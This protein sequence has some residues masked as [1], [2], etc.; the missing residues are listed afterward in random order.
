MPNS[1]HDGA[2][3]MP[4]LELISMLSNS[5]PNVKN[6]D[7]TRVVET[8]KRA[9]AVGIDTLLIGYVS[10]RADSWTV[11][12]T[13]LAHTSTLRLLVAHRPGVISPSLFAR[14]AST[15]DM[16][17]SGRVRI[18]IIAGGSPQDQQCEGDFL[19][20]DE[21][22]E[23]AQEY[24]GVAK[25]CWTDPASVTHSGKYY[26]V[27]DVRQEVRPVQ[28]PY[29][30]IYVGGSS[31]PAQQLAADHGDVF[32]M[33]GEPLAQTRERIDEVRRL[34]A[35]SGQPDIRFSMS[36]RIITGR[37]EDDAW[38]KANDL[39]S[40][41]AK[42]AP[43]SLDQ[44]QGRKRLLELANKNFVY[45]ERLWMGIAAHTGGVGATAALVGTEEQVIAALVEYYKVG[46][47]C[48]QLAA[49]KGGLVEVDRDFVGELRH[50]VTSAGQANSI[51]SN[52]GSDSSKWA[53]RP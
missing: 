29:P 44:D 15:L 6:P 8:A 23:R 10:N 27:V 28:S 1:S 51:P 9:E 37:T 18:N 21:R 32:M 2:H 46:V 25:R 52:E 20:H 30:P 49:G 35:A 45:D 26:Q 7:P 19:T 43:T 14:T 12:A 3:Y 41:Q 48:F 36:F 11:A 42:S 34:A 38:S 13:A 47:S 22:Y 53:N 50:R 5:A 17:S 4:E 39:V 16:L 33:W 31:S 24:L 40:G